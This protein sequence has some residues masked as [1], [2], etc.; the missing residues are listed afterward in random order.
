MIK[1]ILYISICLGAHFSAIA[2]TPTISGS[3]NGTFVEGFSPVN[4]LITITDDGSA[5]T[6]NFIAFNS[7][8]E[9]VFSFTDSDATDGFTWESDMGLL[10]PGAYISA[11]LLDDNG[12]TLSQTENLDLTILAKPQWLVN[13][14]VQNVIVDENGIISF[15]GNYPIYNHQYTI[16]TSVKG[17]GGRSL[18][19]SGKLIFNAEFNL[20]TG[21][22]SVSSNLVQVQL[23]LL[24]QF[25]SYIKDIDFTSNC[26]L[27]SNLNLTFVITNEVSTPPI[28]LNMPKVKFPLTFGLSISVDAG[29]SLYATLK[30]QIV[31]GQQDSIWGFIEDT[32]G[33]KTKVV[34]ILTGNG[35]IRGELSVL[36]GIAKVSSSLKTKAR[37]GIGFDYVNVPS[38]LMNPIS[39]GDINVYGDICWKTY[40]FGE[41]CKNLPSFYYGY[42]GDTSHL[43]HSLFLNSFDSNFNTQSITFQDTGTLVL[44]DFSPQPTFATRSDDLY[45]TWIE[46]NGNNGF[47]L[48][49]KLDSVGTA[50]S[51]QKIVA[52]NNNSISNPQIGIL[53]SGS[54]IITWSQSRY[55]FESVP[56]EISDN[57]KALAQ[58]VWFAIYDNNL[59]SIVHSERLN[60]DFTSEESGRAEGEA[61]IA[62]GDNNDAMITWISKDD[63]TNSSDIWFTHLTETSD[64]WDLTV[65]DKLVDLAG[66]NFNVGVV[67]SDS[68]KALV[69]WINDPDGDEDTYDSDLM[70]SEWDG[71]NWSPAEL[72]SN[73]NDSIKLKELSI[74]SNNNYIAIAWT[75][76]HYDNDN[77]F[78]NR[79]DLEVYDAVA[80][81]WVNSSHFEDIDSLY[82]FQKP[83]TSISETGKASICYQVIEMFPDTTFI[84][85]G[86]LYLYTKDLNDVDNNDWTEIT[87][88]SFLC[89]T[90][91]FIWE[92]TAGFSGG[93][94]YYT[95]TQE[96][97]D[98]G[99]VS[100]P[101]N[102]IKFGD[103]DL[104]MVLRGIQINNDLTVSDIAEPMD[105]PAGII[106]IPNRPNFRLLNNYPNPFTDITTIE[107]QLRESADVQLEIFN[108][109]GT[110]V[111]NLLNTKL[112]PG[113]YKTIFKA[114]DL[115]NGMYFAKLTVDGRTT[116]GKLV[117]IK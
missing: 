13:G 87:D 58:D 37:L 105:A 43:V 63:S 33:Q 74:A 116:T 115:P 84:D 34:G 112:S 69:V 55:S 73:N 57:E 79:I 17:I 78:Q 72:L 6:A 27:D 91:T 65:P 67:Y 64:D 47:L 97:N 19:I 56:Q 107:F 66:T 94:R 31:I 68:S 46:H 98:I 42:F 39:T 5:V 59:D 111:A 101:F 51:S 11:I 76:T 62:V 38:S 25:P 23:D 82:Y 12:D 77:D 50:F 93:D 48:F 28:K 44:P 8:G 81:D 71:L 45:A 4:N 75:S 32:A 110:K 7:A 16:P 15:E 114:G 83:I 85:N 30:G 18:D 41:R 100:V 90:N 86:E 113:I 52:N 117:L 104:S 99:V 95:M 21:E 35:F 61:K 9:E 2:Q 108:Y 109:T 20:N 60:D 26:I 103:P 3:L 89:D 80:G 22:A 14:S 96:Y 1:K 10:S 92:L 88:N 40:L 36:G 29:I 53:P 106:E 24:D 102:G 70:F 54:A 49:S